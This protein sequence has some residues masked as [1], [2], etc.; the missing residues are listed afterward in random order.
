[1]R[2]IALL[3][4]PHLPFLI[5]NHIVLFF[6]PASYQYACKALFMDTRTPSKFSQFLSQ[7]VKKYPV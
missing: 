4:Q 6:I 2:Q 5:R 7:N 1:M 3:R